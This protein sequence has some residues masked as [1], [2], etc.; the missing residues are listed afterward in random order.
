MEEKIF[1]K[2]QILQRAIDNNNIAIDVIKAIYDDEPP[3]EAEKV[4]TEII[5]ETI[6]M[7][8]EFEKL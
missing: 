7:L 4:I 1:V 6:R 8:K 5:K 3:P 2:A